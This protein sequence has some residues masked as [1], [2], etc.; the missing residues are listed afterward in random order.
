MVDRLGKNTWG[1]HFES[2]VV[3]MEQ[4]SCLA[5]FETWLKKISIDP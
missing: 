3:F 1:G 4:Q 2:R 5:H